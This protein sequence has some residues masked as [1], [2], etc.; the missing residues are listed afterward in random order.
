MWDP[1]YE[2]PWVWITALILVVVFIAYQSE[3]SL[4]RRCD[5][6]MS[7]AHSSADSMQ[8]AIAC[9]KMRSDA[10]MAGAAAAAAGAIAG[11]GAGGRR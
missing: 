6:F 7:F 4:D 5:K 10:A 2:R 9:E 3:K 11:S 8:A 1:W